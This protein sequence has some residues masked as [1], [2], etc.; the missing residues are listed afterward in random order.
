MGA[1][2]RRTLRVGHRLHP[3]PKRGVMWQHAHALLFCATGKKCALSPAPCKGRGQGSWTGLATRFRGSTA[4]THLIQYTCVCL[5]SLDV[6]RE[7][8]NV[9]ARPVGSRR[10]GLPTPVL[11]FGGHNAHTVHQSPPS[12]TRFH[13]STE[14]K[15]T[16]SADLCLAHL[17]SC[18]VASRAAGGWS[19]SLPRVPPWREARRS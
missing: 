16:S 1:S 8:V 15:V 11:R 18:N 14:S 12:R 6:I 9:P 2:L 3:L 10:A 13:S 5:V 19:E 17:S 4:T 7:H